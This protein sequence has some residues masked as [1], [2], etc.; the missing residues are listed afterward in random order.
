MR[1]AASVIPARLV[2]R[3]KVRRTL[4]GSR[5]VPTCDG[6]TSPPS[7]HAEPAASRSSSCR[8]WWARLRA[9]SPARARICWRRLSERGYGSSSSSAK[10]HWCHHALPIEA[11]LDRHDGLGPLPTGWSRHD[12]RARQEIAVADRV[13][14]ATSDA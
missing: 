2:M 1:V 9:T 14:E 4:E 6:K 11:A 13:L 8:L 12:D 10:F 3:V 7:F 5:G